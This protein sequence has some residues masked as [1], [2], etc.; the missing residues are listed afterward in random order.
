M[1]TEKPAYTMFG[2][3]I[4]DENGNPVMRDL[5]KRIEA[6]VELTK[7]VLE[8]KGGWVKTDKLVGKHLLFSLADL[9]RAA[10]AKKAR[11]AET[12]AISANSSGNEA[13]S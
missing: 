3:P 8:R 9:R 1:E 2:K 5:N 4:K 13:V 12:K 11:E 10:E 7:F 6:Q